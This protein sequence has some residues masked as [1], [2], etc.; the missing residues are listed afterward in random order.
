LLSGSS[1]ADDVSTIHFPETENYENPYAIPKLKSN[2]SPSKKKLIACQD[3]LGS[4]KKSHENTAFKHFFFFLKEYYD[5][6]SKQ[7][8]DILEQVT[9]T[10]GPPTIKNR[11][12]LPL[13]FFDAELMGLL[14]TY[15]A[16]E[17]K[18]TVMG[19][20]NIHY[21][22][23]SCDSYFSA[24][25]TYY[26]QRHPQAISS[27]VRPTGL[28]QKTY[29]TLRKKM[30]SLAE[31]RVTEDGSMTTTPRYTFTFEELVK[32]QKMFQQL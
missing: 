27:S 29:C 2:E 28:T 12:D 6:L 23:Q 7:H 31:K 30:L 17:A 26:D 1:N 18:Q 16:Q 15:F 32:M 24:I 11:N 3:Q 10:R 8:Q 21:A 4:S 19:G 20:P 5:E 25:K 13:K 22:C 14:A 9:G